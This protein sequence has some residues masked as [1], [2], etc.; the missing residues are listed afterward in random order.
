[1]KLSDIRR[2]L[3][4]L[5]P[6]VKRNVSI[7][8]RSLNYVSKPKSIIITGSSLMGKTFV[9][10]QLNDHLE[11]LPSVIK[12]RTI[13][14]MRESLKKI[15]DPEVQLDEDSFMAG[16]VACH[17]LDEF[18]EPRNNVRRVMYVDN[19]HDALIFKE[20]FP[21][22]ITIMELSPRDVKIFQAK[23]KSLTSETDII[24]LDDM[25][26]K[27]KEFVEELIKVD[28]LIFNEQYPSYFDDDQ[29]KLIL[30]TT[31]KYIEEESYRNNDYIDY[32]IGIFIDILESIHAKAIECDE[33]EIQYVDI[34]GV[35]KM[36]ISDKT[37]RRLVRETAEEHPP[38]FDEDSVGI[39]VIQIPSGGLDFGGGDVLSASIS[40]PAFIDEDGEPVEAPGKPTKKK[41]ERFSYSDIHTLGDRM[42][43]QIIGQ[44]VAIDT[45]VD[46]IKI[47]AAK[48]HD[49]KRPVAAFLFTGPSGVGKTE[50]A[51]TLANELYTKPTPLL[52]L[53]MSEYTDEYSMTRLFGSAPG[54]IGSDDGGQLTNFVLQ[55]PRSI[56][57]LDEAEKAHHKVWNTFLQVFDAGR[58]TDGRG[59]NVDFS[60]CVIIMTSNL[61]NSEQ[62][63]SKA[64]FGCEDVVT[65]SQERASITKKAYEKYFLPEFLGRLDAI[66]TFNS[67]NS[68]DIKKIIGLQIHKLADTVRKNH[69]RYD[70]DEDLSDD[71]V[72]WILERSESDRYGARQVQ[73][74]IKSNIMLELADYLI[75]ND[76]SDD[77][78]QVKV[79]KHG[80]AKKKEPVS[81]DDILGLALNDDK[82]RILITSKHVDRDSIT[83]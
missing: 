17:T 3:D 59:I 62:L 71:V 78:P 77:V 23:N 69:S 51:K 53:D 52:R 54:L 63:K 42:K 10:Q 30:K 14:T 4:D 40:S 6:E 34:D 39:N 74:T 82:T 81:R 38:F 16:Q 83:D 31:V 11:D 1:M 79:K 49:D 19:L 61:G 21:H 57:L 50:V 8:N 64:G 60:D 27:W 32:P 68:E 25:L 70:F 9:I 7:I 47:D 28:H 22:A 48:L 65:R 80:K 66:I 56:I 29:L 45:I 24:D 37:I 44:D 43:K 72:E 33:S 41:V 46:A 5:I 20:R 67:L 12:D 73:K 55:N 26:I 15:I 2:E 76:K 13:Y 35:D 75:T 18:L 36:V 58:M